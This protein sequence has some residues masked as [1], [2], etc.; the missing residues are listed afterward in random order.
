MLSAKALVLDRLLY[1]LLHYLVQAERSLRLAY[2][3]CNL[4][5]ISRVVWEQWFVQL[6]ELLQLNLEAIVSY[7]I[8][9]G[10]VWWGEPKTFNYWC[11]DT[12]LVLI[13]D[14][15]VLCF[16]KSRLSSLVFEHLHICVVLTDCIDHHLN[17]QCAQYLQEQPQNQWEDSPIFFDARGTWRQHLNDDESYVG[18]SRH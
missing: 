12:M 10:F 11:D 4:N 2:A 8:V 14:K 1:Y 5:H 3:L 17:C 18:Q 13:H 6:F 7:Y 9:R 16:W 15:H